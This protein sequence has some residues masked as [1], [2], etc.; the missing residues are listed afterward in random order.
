MF[1]LSMLQKRQKKLP[2]SHTQKIVVNGNLT[3][4]I[5]ATP[6]T[7]WKIEYNFIQYGF[8]HIQTLKLQH[9]FWAPSIQ[10]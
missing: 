2:K 8:C 7:L 6:Y 9:I 1:F 10:H 4:P 5:N 3:M